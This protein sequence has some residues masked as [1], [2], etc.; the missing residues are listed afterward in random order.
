MTNTRILLRGLVLLNAAALALLA[1]LPSAAAPQVFK[2][3]VGGAVTYQH[4]PCATG[5]RAPTP[6]VQQLNADRQ[7]KLQQ[8]ASAAASEGGPRPVAP[9]ASTDAGAP[10]ASAFKCDGRTHCSQ[11]HSCAE[12]KYFLAHCPN[13]QMDGNHDGVPCQKQWCNR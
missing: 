12:A 1:A 4:V 8:A 13:V 6:T 5:E 11:M 7:K 3:M 9:A 2:C 10:A